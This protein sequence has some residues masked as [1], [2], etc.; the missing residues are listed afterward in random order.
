MISELLDDLRAES[1]VLDDLVATL[2]DWTVPTP[3]EG[4]TI[5]HQI[6]H[7][8]WTDRVATLAA[9]DPEAFTEALTRATADMVDEGAQEPIT[10][11]E[12]R[13][14]RAELAEALAALPPGVKMPWF[15]PPMSAASMA[16]A[17]LMET[18][19]HGQDVADALGVTREPTHRL[20]HVAHIA[21]RT[22]GW[23]FLVNGL[24][25]P[26]VPVRVELVA[27]DGGR[28]EWGPEDAENRIT[29]PALDFCL[30][31]TQRRHRDDLAVTAVGEA[32]VAWLP[33]AQ[34]FA[35]PPGTGREQRE[36]P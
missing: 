8:R 7:L 12:W 11:D 9:R 4:W 28:W 31:A 10:L 24:P 16:T 18:W 26:Q 25:V 2:P 27:P 15:G 29:G 20:K 30:L 6:S 19:A 14:A 1:Q 36:R 3:A 22:F 23:S 35:G 5:A 13:A 33:I 34:A 21:V 17:R 32:A